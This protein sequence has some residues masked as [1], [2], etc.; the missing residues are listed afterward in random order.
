MRALSP[1]EW[2]PNAAPV[3]KFKA[4]PRI[5][6]P[7]P[8]V[9]WE[10]MSALINYQRGACLATAASD[11][12]RVAKFVETSVLPVLNKAHSHQAL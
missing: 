7:H 8:G 6:Q 10:K 4:A 3:A 12:G 5:A 9:K 2:Q 1:V 11:T